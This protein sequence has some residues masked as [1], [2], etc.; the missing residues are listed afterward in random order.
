MPVSVKKTDVIILACGWV[1]EGS[2]SWHGTAMKVHYLWAKI[3][4]FLH[5]GSSRL[6][7]EISVSIYLGSLI[8]SVNILIYLDRWCEFC[9][10]LL[11]RVTHWDFCV[12][13][14]LLCIELKA[15]SPE[16]SKSYW[17]PQ[18]DDC[19]YFTFISML[20]GNYRKSLTKMHGKPS[21]IFRNWGTA[22]ISLADTSCI[23]V[24]A[25]HRPVFAP[26]QVPSPPRAC[27]GYQLQGQ[28]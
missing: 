15:Q 1:G 20:W 5:K 23:Q 10:L 14:S 4:S 22:L 17:I 11:I 19:D 26:P 7:W 6:T 12:L 27:F 28:I 8:T 21:K 2:W 3:Q 18:S 25:P 16:S 9:F 13:D 24:I